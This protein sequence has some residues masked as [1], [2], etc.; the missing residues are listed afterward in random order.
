MIRKIALFVICVSYMT[1]GLAQT[2]EDILPDNGWQDDWEKQNFRAYE[3]DDLFFLINGG[4]DLYMEFG[5]SD[6]AA[7][8]YVHPE[9]GS[10]YVEVYKMNNDSAAFG[11]FSMNR[12]QDIIRIEPSPWIIFNNNFMHIWKAEYYITISGSGLKKKG[13]RMDYFYLLSA[14]IENISSD[15][16]LPALYSEFE[17]EISKSSF[18]YIKGNIALSNIYSFGFKD[19]FRIN[20][21]LLIEEGNTKKIIFQYRTEAEALEIFREVTEFVKESDRFG[22]FSQR[23]TGLFSATDRNERPV[24]ATLNNDKIIIEIR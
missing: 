18:S 6:V 11:V 16:H 5:F 8:D 13:L 4:A 19:V 2:A 14:M 15:G 3:G 20:E 9:K 24:I 17:D 21:A 23:E 7:A 22:H 12:G 10:L 1:V